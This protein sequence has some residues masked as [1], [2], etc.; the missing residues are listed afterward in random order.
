MS[1]GELFLGLG[2][3]TLTDGATLRVRLD[4]LW[5]RTVTPE[6][7]LPYRYEA[8][9]GDLLRVYGQGG[10][11]YVVAVVQG[12]GRAAL[13]ALGD[14]ELGAGAGRLRLEGRRAV[15][16]DG[17]PELTLRARERLGLAADALREKAEQ[18]TRWARRRLEA[19][20][21]QRRQVVEEDDLRTARRSSNLAERAVKVDGGLV[22]IGH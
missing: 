22:Q 8:A 3:V 21:G 17:G 9:E 19:R 7:A 20:L 6:W 12:E 18:A 10:R 15:L 16:L 1:G 11:Y 4:D 2:R 5:G 14:L 13:G